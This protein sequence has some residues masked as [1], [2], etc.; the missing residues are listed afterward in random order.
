MP[1][2]CN[3]SEWFSGPMHA[4]NTTWPMFRQSGGCIQYLLARAI[5][6]IDV[7]CMSNHV[8]PLAG[9]FRA[10]RTSRSL[11]HTCAPSIRY[12]EVKQDRKNGCS[13]D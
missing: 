13:T 10:V 7:L 5:N 12:A 11:T 9:P 2:R 3:R 1:L 6:R 8:V 4:L